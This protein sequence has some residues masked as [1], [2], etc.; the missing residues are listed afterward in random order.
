MATVTAAPHGGQPVSTAEENEG[1]KEKT[2]SRS[3]G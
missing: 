2:Y 1:E 3:R